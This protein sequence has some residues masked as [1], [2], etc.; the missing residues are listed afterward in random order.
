VDV[1]HEEVA[2][3][4]IEVGVQSLLLLGELVDVLQGLVVLEL[5][6]EDTQ[7][8][9]VFEGRIIPFPQLLDV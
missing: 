7:H 9:E 2:L 6:L 8:E 3:E 4:M 5:L 1:V